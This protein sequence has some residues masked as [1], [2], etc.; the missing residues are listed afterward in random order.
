MSTRVPTPAYDD[1]GTLYGDKELYER[2]GKI[3][4]GDSGKNVIEDFE[5]PIRS[6]K[7]WIVKKGKFARG[8]FAQDRQTLDC[9]EAIS[10]PIVGNNIM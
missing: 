6:G 5:I 4:E 3:A 9:L 1:T 7:A 2:L 10:L 8:T